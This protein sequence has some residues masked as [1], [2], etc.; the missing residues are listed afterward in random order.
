M[1][2]G[3]TEIRWVPFTRLRSS[4]REHA[5]GRKEAAGDAIC[6]FRLGGQRTA[7]HRENASGAG[8]G[9]SRQSGWA[10]RVDACGVGQV[11]GGAAL[12]VDV[13]PGGGHRPRL[14]GDGGSRTESG[15]DE[16]GLTGSGT[17]RRQVG[18]AGNGKR[19]SDRIGGGR[20]AALAKRR[21][22]ELRDDGGVLVRDRRSAA[23]AAVEEGDDLLEG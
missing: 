5:H 4:Y 9:D 18:R 7:D 11:L 15:E 8:I 22:E 14:G 21:V 17:G 6:A 3:P 10:V 12:V 2:K 1:Q 23:A 20:E 19:S 13:D 16:S